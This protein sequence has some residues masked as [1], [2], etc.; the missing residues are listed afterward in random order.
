MRA[1]LALLL[2]SALACGDDDG[3]STFDAGAGDGGALE[4]DVERPKVEAERHTSAQQAQA[5]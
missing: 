3:S 1:L 4:G 5:N 2:L